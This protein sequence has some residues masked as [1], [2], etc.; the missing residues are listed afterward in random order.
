[1]PLCYPHSVAWIGGMFV[2]VGALGEDKMW[3][4]GCDGVSLSYLKLQW[5]GALQI[6]ACSNVTF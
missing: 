4:E 3:G 2:R 1:M 5:L 6:Y